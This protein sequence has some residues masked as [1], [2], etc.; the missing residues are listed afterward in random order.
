MARGVID[1]S[2]V[3]K[4]FLEEEFSEEARQLRDDH[5]ADLIEVQAPCLLPFEVLNALRYAK[6]FTPE[7][8][9]QVAETLD[10]FSISLH[11]L[12]GSLSLCTVKLSTSAEI[13]VYDASYAALAQELDIPLYTADDRLLK[14]V[15]GAVEAL[16]I[17]E[18]GTPE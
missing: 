2:V 16:H 11:P 12:E 7:E 8:L 17:G 6:V 15:S 14:A 1:A 9:G 18:Y 5:S 4:W 13:S 10:R 3:A